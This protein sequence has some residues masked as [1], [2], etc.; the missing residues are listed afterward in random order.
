MKV[1]RN[2]SLALL[3]KKYYNIRVLNDLLQRKLKHRWSTDNEFFWGGEAGKKLSGHMHLLSFHY[4][5]LYDFDFGSYVDVGA[6]KCNESFFELFDECHLF[7]PNPFYTNELN[8]AI[9]QFDNIN[10]YEIALTDEQN[11]KTLHIGDYR[12]ATLNKKYAA[13]NKDFFKHELEVSTNVLD[14]YDFNI[15]FLKID[16]DGSDADVIIGGEKII[17]KEKPLIFIEDFN[18]EQI[19]KCKV[20][21]ECL[22]DNG[23][24]EIS[25]QT[26][27][28]H[29]YVH[30][31]RL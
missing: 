7:E 15:D 20:K 26:G 25:G 4:M 31:E 22:A 27:S 10:L 13:D 11:T 14:N 1:G 21:F 16:T 8:K 5:Y 28:N 3:S 24:V 17:A 6:Q 9:S 29:F 2:S 30:R 23:F 19:D 18:V 12:T